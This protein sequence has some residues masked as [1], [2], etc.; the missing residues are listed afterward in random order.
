MI[1][2]DNNTKT[3]K[4]ADFTVTPVQHMISACTGAILTSLMMTPFDVVKIRLQSQ[5]KP[6]SFTNGKCFLYCNGLMDH[7]CPCGSGPSAEWYKRPGKFNGTLDALV[8][9]VRLEGVTSLWSG[10]PPTLMMAIPSTVVYFTSYEHLKKVLGYHQEHSG[11]R[12]K[13][14]VAGSVARDIYRL[15]PFS[16]QKSWAASLISPIEMV[17]TKC[18]VR[19]T[20]RYNGV[21]GL[22]RGLG[23][24]LLRDVPF[25]AIYWTSYETFKSYILTTTGRSTLFFHESFG[26]GALAG[27][28]AAV[29]TLPFDVIKTRRQIELGELLVGSRKEPTSTW[30][31]IRNIYSNE[32]FKA[33]Y[34]GLP[35]RLMKVAP[36]CAIMISTFEYFKHFFASRQH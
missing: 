18:T 24:T 29:L 34:T 15:S 33:L 31:I 26:S 36:A 19:D 14:M 20:V 22:Y 10:L 4:S 16:I 11:D 25:S 7:L 35:P 21:L 3:G 23:P 9:I 2:G 8:K 30:I 28:I 1:A 5:A 27:S 12:W 32:G 13:P 17:R 6:S